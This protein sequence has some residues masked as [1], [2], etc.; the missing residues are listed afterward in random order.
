MSETVDQLT[1]AAEEEFLELWTRGPS[2][3][4]WAELPPQIGDAAPD[5]PLTDHTGATVR[6]SEAWLHRPALLIFWRHFGCGCGLARAERLRKEHADYV[7]VGANVVIIGQGEPERAAAYRAQQELEPPI[8]CDPD[9]VAYHTYGL[10]DATVSQV[11]YDAPRDM[12]THERAVGEEFQRSRREQGRPLVDSP[13][14]LQGEFV[15]DTDGTIRLAHRYQHC[16]DFPEP[17]VLIAAIT[18]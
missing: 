6:L 5:L 11:L 16:E 7:G 13:W 18:G 4:T 2:Q 8:L 17:L 1:R 10:R 14:L 9:Y 12:W 3:T 15:V